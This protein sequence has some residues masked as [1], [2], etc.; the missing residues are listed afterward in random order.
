MLCLSGTSSGKAARLSE[1]SSHRSV[2]PPAEHMDHITLWRGHIQ[3][4]V[5]PMR[6]LGREGKQPMAA[7]ACTSSTA[8]R[9]SIMGHCRR[10]EGTP[11]EELVLC[12]ILWSAVQTC[13]TLLNEH[14]G[15]RHACTLRPA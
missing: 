15:I 10:G 5:L 6:S 14:P 2:Y 12:S 4:L 3:A 9:S 8:A 7:Q 11:S 1:G 13:V